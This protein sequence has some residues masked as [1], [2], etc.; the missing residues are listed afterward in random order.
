MLFLSNPSDL[1]PMATWLALIPLMIWTAVWKAIAMWKAARN[2]HK[3]WFIF[4]AIFNLL[5]I[6]EI[7]YILFW[8]NPKPVKKKKK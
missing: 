2:D 1:I 3:A 6:P 8:A 4:F 5:A 7:L